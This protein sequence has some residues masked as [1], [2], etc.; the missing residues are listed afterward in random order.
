VFG[1][2]RIDSIDFR[3]G[4]CVTIAVVAICTLGLLGPVYGQSSRP[5]TNAAVA[6]QLAV[7]CLSPVTDSLSGFWLSTTHDM[8][9]LRPALANHWSELGVEV[10]VA[11]TLLGLGTNGDDGS[12]GRPRLRYTPESVVTRYEAADGDLISRSVTLSLAHTLAAGDGRLLSDDRCAKTYEDDVDRASIVLIQPDPFPELRAE[13]PA[14]GSWRDWGEPAI[15]AGA[16]GVV[17]YLFFT[18]RSS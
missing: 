1:H 9:Y 3:I 6:G 13:I 12:A 2:R 4:Q 7:D 18:V 16:V 14:E 5:P 15:L 11:D 8:P 10:F 17:A